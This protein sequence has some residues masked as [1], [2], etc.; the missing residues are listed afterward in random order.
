MDR[1]PTEAQR[2]GILFEDMNSK[3]HLILEGQDSLRQELTRKMKNMDER[4]SSSV[5]VI[6]K[7]VSSLSVKISHQ[8]NRISSLEKTVY[9]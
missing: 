9:H 3:F 5:A 6:E 7:A 1:E 2:V 4:I 8:E